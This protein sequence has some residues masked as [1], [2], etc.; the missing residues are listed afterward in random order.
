MLR[1]IE[2]ADSLVLDPHKT[3]FL[4]Y[5][6]GAL[7]VREGG[8]LR[9]AHSSRADY[10][11]PMQEDDDFM[12]FCELSP[13]LTR[14]FR[15][16][17]VWLPIKMHGVSVFRD[18]L[19]EK[20]D[21]TR[22]IEDQI[23]NIPELDVLAPAELSIMAFAVKDTGQSLDERNAATRALM[24]RINARQRVHLTGTLLD[25]VFAIRICI[26]LFRAHQDRIEM[27][28]EDLRAALNE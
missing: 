10:M 4:P 19:D 20:L 26:V 25:G 6:T 14:P 8:S 12:D 16:L 17:R 1:G 23:L 13:E 24:Q 7:L 21:L 5:G 11:P 27:L 22:W 2:Q 9:A 3:L 15:G 18:Y 28:L